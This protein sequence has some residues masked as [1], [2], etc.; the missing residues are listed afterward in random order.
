M[1]RAIV[2]VATRDCWATLL[3]QGD[4]DNATIAPAAAFTPGG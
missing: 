4:D 1:L 3:D 2:D